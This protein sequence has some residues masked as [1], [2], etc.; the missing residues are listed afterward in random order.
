[1]ADHVVTEGVVVATEQT[2]NGSDLVI[3]EG[4]AP[5][6]ITDVRVHLPALHEGLAVDPAEDV[7]P[8]VV[9]AKPARRGIETSALTS[10]RRKV[11]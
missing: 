10:A 11:S 7:S 9:D 3:G 1:V 6:W 5:R 4:D 2:H 8:V